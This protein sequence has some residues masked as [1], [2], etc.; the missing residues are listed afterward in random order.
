MMLAEILVADGDSASGGYR[1]VDW[2]ERVY[3]PLRAGGL[4]SRPPAVAAAIRPN[5]QFDP[6]RNQGEPVSLVDISPYAEC[7][8]F[9]AQSLSG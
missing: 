9:I 6:H 8:Q 3:P 1:V 4:A 2:T 5:N 7:R